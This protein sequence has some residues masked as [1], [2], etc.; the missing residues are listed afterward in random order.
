MT[1]IERIQTLRERANGQLSLEEKRNESQRLRPLLDGA[2]KLSESLG[3]EVEQLRLL[4]D[5]G[6]SVSV[7]DSSTAARKTLGR[8]RERFAK[9]MRTEQL[10]RGRDWQRLNEQVLLTCQSLSSALQAEWRR[11]VETAFSGD[12]PSNLEQTLASTPKNLQNLR[13]FQGGYGKLEQFS[14]SRPTGR[15]DFEQVR[16]LAR[17]LTEIYQDFDFDVPEDVNRFL[18]AVADGGADLALLTAG[19]RDW[20][21]GQDTSSHYR[22]VAR[23]SSQ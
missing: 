2:R 19:V 20:L 15:A 14:R 6:I 3:R 9:E 16:D 8:L 4:Q 21:E 18:R 11:I 23:L 12:K 13:R 1:L 5:Q 7:P 10:T 17:Q 22:I